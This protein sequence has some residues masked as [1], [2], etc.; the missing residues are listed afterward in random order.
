MP[1]RLTLRELR[2]TPVN[3]PLTNPVHTASGT[4]AHAPLVLIDL[5]THEGVEGRAYLFTYTPLALK[6]VVSLLE[7]MA[8]ILENA[9]LSPHEL[10]RLLDARFRL[11]GNT[12]LVTM[13]IAG[14][15]MAAWDALAH[16][17]GMPLA[18]LLGG[19]TRGVRAYFSQGMESV[20]RS[21]ELAQEAL[22]RGFKGMK[23]KIGHP[24]VEDDL[25]VVRAVKSCL[26]DR[27]VLFVDYNQSLS[28]PDAL[29]RCR[30]LDEMELDWIEEPTLQHDYAGHAKI[31]S[32]I[33]TPIQLGENYFGTHEM[34]KGVAAHASDLVMPDLMKIGGV[35]GWLRAA[36][37]ADAARLP[38][39]SHIFQE[40]SAHL[41]TVTPT[42][43]WLEHLD[44][45][46]PVLQQPLRIEAGMAVL[47]ETP[48][49]GVSWNADAVAK[50][51]ID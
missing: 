4:I 25:A 33:R 22:A 44:I 23:I 41:M 42:A 48:G 28:V 16:A 19:G 32:E 39:S 20:D 17:A 43:H 10:E 21:V 6:P 38:M 14:L 47:N 26:G 49:A 7:A 15:D 1:E 36:S 45:A 5:L 11:L 31:A 50:Y 2:A 18:R 30:V 9:V 37:L 12:G 8:G 24:R 34:A 51:R 13:A 40:F 3:V 27:A 35:S 46:A 29:D